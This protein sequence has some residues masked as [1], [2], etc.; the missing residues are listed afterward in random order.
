MFGASSS[1]T[2][3]TLESNDVESNEIKQPKLEISDGQS[4]QKVENQE[5]EAEQIAR[6]SVSNF[7]VFT[8]KM[9]IR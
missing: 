3:R 1:G 4:V 6:Q 9:Q 7:F 8:L 5:D 2:K